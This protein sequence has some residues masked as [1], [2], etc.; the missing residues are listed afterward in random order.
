MVCF[1][2]RLCEHSSVHLSRSSPFLS[3]PPSPP[4]VDTTEVAKES[5]YRPGF[6]QHF[7]KKEQQQ[8]K[9][10]VRKQQ[11]QGSQKVSYYF[12]DVP[13]GMEFRDYVSATPPSAGAR[14]QCSRHVPVCSRKGVVLIAL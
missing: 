6:M 1:G 11:P 13:E 7:D 14:K 3:P 10:G 5:E 4:G 2:L 9:P 8:N 12:P